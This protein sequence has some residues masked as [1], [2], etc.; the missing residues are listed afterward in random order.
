MCDRSTKHR[1]GEI[2]CH[3]YDFV[4]FLM[5][6][7][8][9]KALFLN[10]LGQGIVFLSVMLLVDLFKLYWLKDIKIDTCEEQNGFVSSWI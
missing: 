3:I 7:I 6:D 4:C 1:E 5:T 10:S 9:D 8:W 2:Y